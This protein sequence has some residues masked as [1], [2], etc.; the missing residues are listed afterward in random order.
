[1]KLTDRT[2]I[3]SLTLFTCQRQ[4]IK[5]INIKRDEHA[6]YYGLAQTLCSLREE[7]KIEDD[8]LKGLQLR[9]YGPKATSVRHCANQ[10]D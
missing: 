8:D 6:K 7:R 2:T 10:N 9:L 1:M 3:T 5:K 4:K